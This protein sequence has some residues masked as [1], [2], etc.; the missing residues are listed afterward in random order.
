MQH[1]YDVLKLPNLTSCEEHEHK[2]TMLYFFH[3][4]RNSS[5]E[6][7][8]RKLF[9]GIRAMNLEKA[10]IHFSREVFATFVVVLF[11]WEDMGKNSPNMS[12]TKSRTGINL[13]AL[14]GF[15]FLSLIAPL[16]KPAKVKPLCGFAVIVFERKAWTWYAINKKAN[17]LFSIEVLL[18]KKLFE[19]FKY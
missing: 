2:T 5:L 3:K 17:V 7:N 10:P 1:H 13:H 6:F 8:S 11:R 14:S 15:N 12:H 9:N 19:V 4:H 18:W 16:W